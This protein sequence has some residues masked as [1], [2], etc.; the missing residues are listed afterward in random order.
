MT[1]MIARF[2]RVLLVGAFAL[3]LAGC[4]TLGRTEDNV[5][6]GGVVGATTGLAVTV[7]TGGC[8]PCGA[9]IGGASGSGAGF[10]YSRLTRRAGR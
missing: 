3:T 4:S 8:V 6:I 5:L 1:D 10:I 2:S 9:A 7:A